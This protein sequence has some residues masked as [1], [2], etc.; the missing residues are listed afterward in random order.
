[1]ALTWAQKRR[2]LIIGGAAA[3]ALVLLSALVFSVVYE[4]P[5][6]SDRKQNQGE[7]GIDCG[8]GC[9]RI[10]SI[11]LDAP[12]VSFARALQLP[13]GR[14]DVIAYIENR[15]RDAETKR[16]KYTIE[17]YDES[18]LSLATKSATI[19]LPAQSIVPVFESGMYAGPLNATRAFVTFDE[20]IV[21][22]KPKAELIVPIV[23][24]ADFTQGAE[25]RVTAELQ[26][27]SPHALYNVRLVATAFDSQGNAIA[28]SQTVVREIPA[29]GSATAVFTWSNPFGDPLRVEVVP[30]LPLP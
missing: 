6:C 4:T 10:C 8:G 12:R 15:N 24:S 18:G 11:T 20:D 29:Q 28:A 3:L 1:M 22:T 19:D 9:A 2:S 25:P 5:T 16:A 21:W 14:T 26:N 23:A 7:T 27:S 13:N 17:L 30:V